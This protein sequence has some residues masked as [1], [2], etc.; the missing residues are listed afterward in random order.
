[1]LTVIY[2]D[3]DSINEREDNRYAELIVNVKPS[4]PKSQLNVIVILL[5]Q[6]S[7]KYRK[8]RAGVGTQ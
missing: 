7:P 2:S 1:M 4:D 8:K 6:V 3:E 5:L